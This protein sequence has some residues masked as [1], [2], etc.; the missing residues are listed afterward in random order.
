MRVN[1]CSDCITAI[2]DRGYKVFVGNPV[3]YSA[4]EMCEAKPE[5]DL[6]E[7][8]MNRLSFI[9]AC[10]DLGYINLDEIFAE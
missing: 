6:I 8:G 7:C 10:A 1:L 4:C 2:K 5:T 3:V 9:S